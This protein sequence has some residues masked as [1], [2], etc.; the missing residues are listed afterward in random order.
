MVTKPQ[1]KRK[2]DEDK[3]FCISTEEG[4]NYAL[5]LKMWRKDGLQKLIALVTGPNNNY[6]DEGTLTVQPDK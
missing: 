6:F 3:K 4:E 2:N 5:T 1:E